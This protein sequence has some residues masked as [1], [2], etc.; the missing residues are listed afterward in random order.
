MQASA[1]RLNREFLHR[2]W[3]ALKI[4]IGLNSGLMHVGDMGSA[5]R[6]AYTV[7]GDAVNLGARL[8]GITKVYGVGIAA[9]EATRMA[10]PEFAWRELDLVRVK[11]KNE[12]VAIFEPLGQA[13][14]LDPAVHEELGAW[15]AALA[16]VRAQ[17]WDAAQEAIGALQA[18][19]PE[20]AL[21]ALY[22][23]RIAHYRRTPPGPDW[24]GVT[25][26]ETK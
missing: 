21:Y 2:G 5:I 16:L 1:E 15:D 10:A 17:Q 9:G 8:E 19:H 14:E 12:P 25:S 23:E 20:R 18:R 13:G 3:P 26:F 22:L 11:G 6:R 24:D 7:M 4:G